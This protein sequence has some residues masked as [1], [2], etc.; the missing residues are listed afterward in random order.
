MKR[1]QGKAVLDWMTSHEGMM[2]N[3]S[4]LTDILKEKG[5]INGKTLKQTIAAR[6]STFY[7][8]DHILH[9]TDV[10]RPGYYDKEHC[11]VYYNPVQREIFG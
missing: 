11:Y 4:E 6:L 1:T 9:K 10:M 5:W 8:K 2:V 7:K 3:A